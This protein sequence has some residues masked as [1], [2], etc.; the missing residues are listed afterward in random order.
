MAL[1]NNN[2]NTRMAS[3][4]AITDSELLTIL[5]FSIKE[6]EIKHLIEYVRLCI[7]TKIAKKDDKLF[8]AISKDEFW[9]DVPLKQLQ[10][11]KDSFR[12]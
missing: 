7:D 11:I 1:F 5:N 12:K 3:V 9:L 10:E 6:L 2:S 4:K 8:K